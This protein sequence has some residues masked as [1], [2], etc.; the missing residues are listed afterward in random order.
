MSTLIELETLANTRDLGGMVASDGRRIRSGKLIRSGQLVGLSGSDMAKLASMVDTVIDFRNSGEIEDQ[1]D[2][3]LDGVSNINIPIVE[4]FTSGIS[5][6]E[7][8]DEQLIANLAFRPEAAREYMRTMYRKFVTDF[9]ISRYSRF[10]EVLLQ[11]HGKAVLWHC[12]AGKDRAGIG[13]VII[14]EILGV[15]REEII[16]DYMRT[17]NFLSP[18]TEGYVTFIKAEFEKARKLSEEETK[19]AEE[20]IRSLFG[21][22]QSY[23]EA[24]YKEIEKQF[25]DYDTFIRR[26][27]GLT[28]RQILALRDKYLE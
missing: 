18:Y 26:G 14:E 11:D 15:P 8:S 2:C 16:A 25:G 7:E 28:D 13:A 27:L 22:E 12:S 9:C 21:I 10:L 17:K 4:N 3:I 20:S 5:R 1:P 6:E 23:I 19:T 24:Y